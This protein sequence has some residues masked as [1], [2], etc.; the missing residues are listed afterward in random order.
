MTTVTIRLRNGGQPDT[1]NLDDLTPRARTLAEA[2]A[3]TGQRDIWMESDAPLRDRVP[4]WETWYTPE[5]AA[6]PERRPWRGWAHYPAD[7]TVSPIQ[8]LEAQ[9][10]KIPPGWHVLGSH[11]EHPVPSLAAGAADAHLDS[12]DAPSYLSRRGAPTS[13]TG[14]DTL[15]G[16][17]HLPEPDRYVQG[18]PQWRPATLDAYATRDVERWTVSRVADYLGYGG[19]PA[20]AAGSAR[21]Q[22]SRWGLL[23][24]DR[25]PGRGGQGRYAADQVQAAHAG[26]PR[27]GRT[28]R[29]GRSSS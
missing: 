1:I 18:R 7:S 28:R 8:Y 24:L 4:D 26:R 29:P 11:P 21:R 15:T 14:W 17:G 20:T 22:L 16:T 27:P 6:R 5:E 12:R 3:Q 2:L 13:P 23:P 25:A 10:S 9:A 19:S